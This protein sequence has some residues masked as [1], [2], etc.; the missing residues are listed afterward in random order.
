MTN[1]ALVDCLADEQSLLGFREFCKL[2][3]PLDHCRLSALVFLTAQKDLK[4]ISSKSVKKLHARFLNADAP[5]QINYFAE[6][7]VVND[8]VD[9]K[10]WL[11]GV[12]LEA[13]NA[14]RQSDVFKLSRKR[15]FVSPPLSV[16]KKGLL[17]RPQFQHDSDEWF[18]VQITNN[19]K[20]ASQ[21]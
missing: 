15:E 1:N 9:L 6:C 12:L 10:Y 18:H 14:F 4:E 2:H 7:L 19:T 13:Y 17:R 16:R 8:L 3:R 20:L 5:N 11:Q 21:S